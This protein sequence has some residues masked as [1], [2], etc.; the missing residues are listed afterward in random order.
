MSY[1]GGGQGGWGDQSGQQGGWGQSDYSDYGTDRYPTTGGFPQQ[2]FGSSYGGLGVFSGGEEPPK[3]SKKKLWI[4]LGA[5]AAVLVIGGGITTVVLLNKSDTPPVAQTTDTSTSETTPSEQT[6]TSTPSKSGSCTPRKAGTTCV[7]TALGYTYDVPKG[8][9]ANTDRV[10]LPSM[11]GVQLSGM[12]D[13]GKYECD[14]KQ[15]TKGTAGGTLVDKGDINKAASDL[16]KAA[17]TDFYSGSPKNDVAVGQP[18]PIKF[19]HKTK[20]GKDITVEGVQ[21]DATSTSS[22]NEC[23]NNKGV[24][25]VLMLVGTTKFH[26]LVVNGDLEGDAGGST[27]ALPRDADLQAVIDSLTPTS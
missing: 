16:A 26:A 6:P 14:G 3:K 20:E 8:W 5:I 4:V 15:W 18:K 23:L 19:Q 24:V 27:P 13:Y 12:S 22:G 9:Q 17:A 11:K 21:V 1:P 25:K 2:G 7:T 10:P